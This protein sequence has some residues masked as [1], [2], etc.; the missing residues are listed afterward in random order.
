M[1]LRS[2]G[3]VTFGG[4]SSGLPTDEI[5]QQLL[6]LERRPINQLSAQRDRFNAQL[7]IFQDLSAKTTTLRNALREIDNLALL[8]N[9][10]SAEEE[11]SQ[12]GATSSDSSV[13]TATATGRASPGT[14]TFRVD[15]LATAQRDISTTPYAT[16][17]DAVGEGTLTITI[18]GQPPTVV[19]IDSSNNSLAGLVAAI[20]DSGADVT[21]SILDTNN[22]ATP[23]QLVI[24]GNSTGVDNAVTLTPGGGLGVTFPPT[25]S[26]AA[27]DAKITIDPTNPG[28]GTEVSSS[29]NTF[30]D[31]LTGVSLQLIEA[32]GTTETITIEPDTDAIVSAIS[33]VVSAFNAVT[34]IIQE[35][36]EIDPSTNRGGVAIGAPELRSLLRS[37]QGVIASQ[38]GTGDISS[39]SQIGISIDT[40]ALLSL[41]EDELRDQL[42]AGFDD[43]RSFFAGEDGFADGLREVADRFVDTV[44]GALTARIAGT[45]RSIQDIT[46]QITAAE[47]RLTTV[48]ENLVRQFSALERVVSEVQI[49]GNFLA[50]FLIQSQR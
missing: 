39:A 5:I 18:G 33:D 20:N 44:D 50:Q 13:V 19:T 28:P 8:G 48:E 26:Q 9:G 38:L 24:Q 47:D 29:S 23:L 2:V 41:D 45:S 35:Q 37:L 4:I 21:A 27:A 14:L 32:N 7:Q 15:N 25:P 16:E 36:F 40:N 6:E 31:V 43:V 34:A 12:F 17:D 22:G 49:Q 10:A 42:A 11:F 3:S 1:G 30:A 46:D